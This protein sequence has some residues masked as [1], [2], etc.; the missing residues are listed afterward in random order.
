MR[1]QIQTLL[2]GLMLA[3]RFLA[4]VYRL[5]YRYYTIYYICFEIATISLKSLLA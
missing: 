4:L 1:T 5:L 3:T 2:H